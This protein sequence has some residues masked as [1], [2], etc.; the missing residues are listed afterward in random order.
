MRTA[1]CVSPMH[2]DK[3]CDRISD[4]LLDIHLTHDPNSRVAIETC[5]GN[6]LVYVTG[7]VTSEYKITDEQI[8]SVVKDITT[9]DSI[10]V[11]ININTQSPEIAQGVDTGGAGDQGI[12][13]G[14]ACQE[15]DNLMPFE[16]EHARRL[17]KLIYQ[18][19]PYD[20]KTQVTINGSDVTAVASFQNA[21][22]SDLNELVHQYFRE[23]DFNVTTTH[24]NPAGD[25]NIGGFEAD[26]GLTGR[27]LAVDNYGPRVPLGGGAFSGKDSTKVDRSA[28]YMARKIAVDA[29]REHQLQ[30]ALVELS[31]A[32]GYPQPLQA[33]IKGNKHGINI[34]TGLYFEYVDTKKYDL[35]PKGIIDFLDLRKP[36][37]GKTAEYGHMG[38]GFSWE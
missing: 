22:A 8:E 24:C 16:Y 17:N 4:T 7:E 34:E 18:H 30:Y 32:I 20:G 3:M 38:A 29:L 35:S 33:A 37:F 10:K 27:K 28:A 23:T 15:T 9:D 1:E 13:I 26:A 36:I 11:I 2:P 14:Y 31:Y 21:K 5:G 19:F 12:M 25:W 6:G